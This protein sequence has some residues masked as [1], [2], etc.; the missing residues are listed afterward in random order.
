MGLTS[1]NVAC[2]LFGCLLLCTLGEGAAANKTSARSSCPPDHVYISGWCYVVWEDLVS[3]PEAYVQCASLHAGASL[4]TVRDRKEMQILGNVLKSVTSSTRAWIGLSKAEGSR[5]V[6]ADGSRYR[7]QALGYLP[8]FYGSTCIALDNSAGEWWVASCPGGR[9][10]RA[11][12]SGRAFGQ[13]LRAGPS[14]LLAWPFTGLLG[15]IGVGTGG[16]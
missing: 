12:P 9:A 4:A 8:S 1:L 6:W 15:V 7:P 10:S 14:S 2:L 16:Y 3:W 11:G 13:G 5:W